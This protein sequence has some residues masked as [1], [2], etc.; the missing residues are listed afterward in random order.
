[1][2]D[3]TGRFFRRRPIDAPAALIALGWIGLWLLW[4]RAG[5]SYAGRRPQSGAVRVLPAEDAGV[6][7][8]MTPDLF[9]RPFQAGFRAADDADTAPAVLPLRTAPASRVLENAG[10]VPISGAS[11]PGLPARAAAGGDYRPAP[12]WTPAFTAASDGSKQLWATM[13]PALDAAGFRVPDLPA[14]ITAAGAPW[15]AVLCVQLGADGRPRDVFVEKS[16]A[17]P[18][19]DAALAR[20]VGEGRAART[21]AARGYVTLSF[22]TK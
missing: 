9:G 19:L 1:M 8:Y 14:G 11:R 20:A 10:P 15:M 17:D 16:T 4:P 22:G 21:N 18:A 5:A 3:G 12:P 6:A 7:A 13:T 2:T